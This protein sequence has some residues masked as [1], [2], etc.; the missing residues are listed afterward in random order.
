MSFPG[1]HFCKLVESLSYWWIVIQIHTWNPENG[2]PFQLCLCW[3][4]STYKDQC[5]VYVSWLGQ[6]KY[7]GILLKILFFLKTYC[8]S[9]LKGEPHNIASWPQGHPFAD[10]FYISYI[11]REDRK[12]ICN[13]EKIYKSEHVKKFHIVLGSHHIKKPHMAPYLWLICLSSMGFSMPW[14]EHC[15]IW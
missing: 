4:R 8:H 10:F 13:N 2:L 11:I 3:S 12:R 9:P 14:M 1:L 15:S 6:A 7:S 5:R